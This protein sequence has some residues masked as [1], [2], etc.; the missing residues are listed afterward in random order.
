SIDN[1]TNNLARKLLSD[2]SNKYLRFDFINNFYEVEK[3]LTLGYG[4]ILDSQI[5]PQIQKKSFFRKILFW[6]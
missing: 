5:I 2:L 4:E 1:S 6:K 3:K